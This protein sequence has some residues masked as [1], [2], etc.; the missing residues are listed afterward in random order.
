MNENEKKEYQEYLNKLKKI[1]FLVDM[2]HGDIN[3]ICV[4][5]SLAEY[6]DMCGVAKRHLDRLAD[7]AYET[8]MIR[9]VEKEESEED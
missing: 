7:M 3:R 8:L 9:L 6:E 2:I 4:T 5:D 1:E